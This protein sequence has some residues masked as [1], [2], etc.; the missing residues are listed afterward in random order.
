MHLFVT[1]CCHD[2]EKNKRA[3]QILQLEKWEAAEHRW[4][5]QSSVLLQEQAQ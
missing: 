4:E 2:F 5:Q 3:P 1:L